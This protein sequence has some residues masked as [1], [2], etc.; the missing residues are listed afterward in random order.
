MG[1]LQEY[2]SPHFHVLGFILGGYGCRSCKKTP[3]ID[4]CRGCG[5]FEDRTRK[6]YATDGY[7]VK[8]LGKRKTVFGTAWYQLNH[9]TIDTTK[10]RFHVATWFGVCSYRKLKVTVEKREELCPCC[11]HELK[12]LMYCGSKSFVTDR[13]SSNYKRDSYEDYEEDG[14]L[15]WVEKEPKWGE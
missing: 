12:W 8:A 3:N 6:A 10:K 11:Q 7:I 1:Q 15:V 2:W 14:Q 5:G 4:V 13:S 9:A